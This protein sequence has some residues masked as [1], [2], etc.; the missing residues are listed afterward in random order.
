MLQY[1][2]IMMFNWRNLLILIYLI[3]LNIF[4]DNDLLY[5]VSQLTVIG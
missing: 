2:K 3:L 5:S 1:L 4:F